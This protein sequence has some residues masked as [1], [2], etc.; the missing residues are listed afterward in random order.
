MKRILP[1]FTLGLLM[2]SC[3]IPFEIE[4]DGEP[5]IYLQCIAANGGVFVSPQYAAPVGQSVREGVSFDVDL[6]VNGQD[7]E[8]TS[9]DGRLFTNSL[10]LK[11]GDEVSVQVKAD[12]MAP[13]SG[14]TRFIAKPLITDLTLEM[15]P[16]EEEGELSDLFKVGLKLDETPSPEEHYGLQIVCQTRSYYSDR[17]VEDKSFYLIPSYI[18]DESDSWSFNLEDYIQV[19]YDGCRLGGNEAYRPL[20]ILPSKRFHGKTYYFYL[21]GYDEELLNEIRDSMPEGDTGMAGGGIV[22]GDVG[23]GGPSEGG[24]EDGDERK[25]LLQ[26]ARYE[27][28]L[29]R[30]SD[31]FFYYFKAL[32]QSNFDFLSNMGLTPANFTYSN[33]SGGLGM[34]GSA[35][36]CSIETDWMLTFIS[37]LVVG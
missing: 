33:V 23:E 13:A 22:S 27:F 3:E 34:V 24:E 36:S 37:E 15:V 29:Y 6:Q 19:N 11:E 10:L 28:I 20:T 8:A 35:S 12:G 30:M 9:Q 7:V 1:I 4:Q 16:K 5:Q 26:T 18:R 14:H 17:N 32:Y 21:G 31:E 25:L 2:A